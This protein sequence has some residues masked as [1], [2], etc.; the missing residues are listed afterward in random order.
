MEPRVHTPR[1]IPS[2]TGRV[3]HGQHLHRFL[4]CIFSF[5]QD[6]AALGE[7]SFS[8]YLGMS[9]VSAKSPQTHRVRH[10]QPNSTF[11]V[12]QTQFPLRI[13]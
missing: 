3:P 13:A 5:Y 11:P 6:H 9:I 1:S 2:L 7:Q 4:Y 8:R 12:F 10:I